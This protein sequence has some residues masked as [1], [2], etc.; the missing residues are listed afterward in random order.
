MKILFIGDVVGQA[1]RRALHRYLPQLQDE[2]GIDLTVVNVENAAGGF[3]V[4]APILVELLEQNAI[5]VLTSGNHIWDRRE[6]LNLIDDEPRLLRP[7]NYPECTPGTGWTIVTAANGVQVGV[8]NVLG[9]VFMQ[10]TLDC[11]FHSAAAALEKKPQAVK[12]VLV[13][14]HA[15]ATSEKVAM[16]W[17]LDGQVSAVVGTHTH[18]PTADERVLPAGT[19]HISDVGMTGCYNSILGMEIAGVLKRF[20]QRVPERFEAATG[21]VWICGVVIDVDEQTGASRGI[22]RVRVN[23][24]D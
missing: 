6:A 14:F 3:G 16:G 11:P 22:K 5:D 19:A 7:H 1:G 21:P 13:D 9:T 17:Y 4:T 2:N 10:P 8:L 18:V 12:V 15:E 24:T 23:E 20:V